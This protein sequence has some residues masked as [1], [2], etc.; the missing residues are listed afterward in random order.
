[1]F[2]IDVFKYDPEYEENERKYKTLSKE[3]LGSSDEGSGNEGDDE[4]DEE[5]EEDG[6]SDKEVNDGKGENTPSS[7]LLR[8]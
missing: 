1:M 5:E 7:L 3:I 6:D 2:F 8:F 4:S